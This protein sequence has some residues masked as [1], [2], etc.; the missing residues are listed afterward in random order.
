MK[1]FSVVIALSL[2]LILA[3]CGSSGPSTKINVNMTDF[4]FDPA[5]FT[6]PVGQQITITA[7]NN[8]AVE[9]EYVIFKLGTDAGNHFGQEDEENIYWE[10]EVKPGDSVTET[11]TAPNEPGTYFVSCGIEGHL[12]A[13]MIGSL[14]VV[15]E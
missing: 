15:G 9:H 10:V 4:M 3:A 6:I 7:T 1:K 11:F 2:S 5:D 14:I 12:E 13:G 8:G